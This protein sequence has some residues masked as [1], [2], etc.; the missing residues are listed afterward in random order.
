MSERGRATQTSRILV[1][2]PD[3]AFRR[4]IV[5]VL[6][7]AGVAV[8]AAPDAITALRTMDERGAPDV[9]VTEAELAGLSSAELLQIARTRW[10]HLAVIVVETHPRDLP[11]DVADA[12]VLLARSE[13]DTRLV[14]AVERARRAR[15]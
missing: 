10:P 13:L 5:D 1:V 3:Q 4:Q 6:G 9:L 14:A 8:A 11:P 12:D 2:T 15:W 7:A